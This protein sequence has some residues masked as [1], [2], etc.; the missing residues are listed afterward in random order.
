MIRASLV[1]LG[2]LLASSGLPAAAADAD[3]PK[4]EHPRPD[5]MRSAL[6][7]SQRALGI[8]L[9]R[10]A[11]RACTAGW[12]KP[13]AP[14]FDRTIVVPFPWESELSGNP[15]A[16]GGSEGRLVSPPLPGSRRLPGRS[17]GLAAVRG[18]RLAGGRLG[19]R[20][21]G[22]RSRGRLH[23]L[24]IRRDRRGRA[25][26]REYRRRPGLRPH[27]SRPA[28]RQAGPLVHPQLGHLADGLARG[29]AAGLHL[30]LPD[31]PGDRPRPGHIRR[32][33][34]RAVAR[35]ASQ[36]SRRGPSHRRRAAIPAAFRRSRPKD[37]PARF[38]LTLDVPEP[39]LWT[40]ETP[41]LYDA[42]LELRGDGPGRPTGSRPTS[43]SARS[44]GGATAT[45]R[46]SGSSST[47]SR[48]I[49]APPWTSRSIPRGS[50]P[51]PTTSS[52]GATWRSPRRWGSTACG[53]TSS[54]T[55][56]GGCTGRI[57]W[58]S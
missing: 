12:E 15:S 19:Q 57:A 28:D 14:G 55:S 23:A 46:S 5:A 43:A 7:Q 50:T 40:P 37:G 9:R 22:R 24:R 49:S 42:T 29:P 11:T 44:D 52:S 17:A 26:R 53:S 2:I 25:G 32:R 3:I 1:C 33:G 35:K 16:E 48:S 36:P 58:G 41:N 34:R 10:R 38:E 56:P 18:R 45:S 27:R 6:V 54:P 21:E 13:D 47:A 30:Q 31:H 51:R 20:A 39:Q 8:P 4:P